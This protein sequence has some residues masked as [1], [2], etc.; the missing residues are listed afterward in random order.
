[1]KLPLIKVIF[2]FDKPLIKVILKDYFYIL[3]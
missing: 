1:L 2:L 3:F